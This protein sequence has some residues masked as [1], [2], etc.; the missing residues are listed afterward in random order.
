MRIYV[1]GSLRNPEVQTV[2]A[3]LRG[4]GHFVF[5]DWQAVGPDADEYWMAYEK[6]RGRT[7]IEALH[8]EAARNTFE[9][10]LRHLQEAE[11]IVMVMPCGK[12]GWMETGW[13]AGQGKGTYALVEEDPERWDVMLRFVDH[14]VS[15]IEELINEMPMQA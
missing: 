6:A 7:Y 10:D 5:D 1:V 11:A 8:G 2:A 3:A 14:V 4:A 12:S 13:A 15:S 9:F